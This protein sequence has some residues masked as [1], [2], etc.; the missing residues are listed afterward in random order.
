[1]NPGGLSEP[2]D[3]L[4]SPTTLSGEPIAGSGEVR[5]GLLE[6]SNVDTSQMVGYFQ[7]AKLMMD[8]SSKLISTNKTL[9]EESL[10]LIQ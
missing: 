1:V 7:Q 10:R 4:F 9:L 2:E 5:S 3:Q 6:K 8:I